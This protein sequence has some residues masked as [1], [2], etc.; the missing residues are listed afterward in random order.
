MRMKVDVSVHATGSGHVK[1]YS[2]QKRCCNVDVDA[3]CRDAAATA[4][5]VGDDSNG[6]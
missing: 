2:Q 4:D 6:Q 1:V 3:D 5:T